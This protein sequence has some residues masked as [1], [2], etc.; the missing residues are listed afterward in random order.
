MRGVDEAREDFGQPVVAP[1]LPRAIVLALLHNHPASIV[2]DDEAV[3]V[4][5]IT[6]LQRG[7]VDLGRQAA[8]ARQQGA[9]QADPLANR[10]Q[11]RG[12]LPGVL[13][14]AAA[15]VQTKLPRQRVE[16]AFERP[17]NAGGDP[18]RVPVHP[19]DCAE[20]L[21]P[22]GMRKTPQQLVATVVMD[23]RLAHHSAQARHALRQPRRDAS[24]MERQVGAAC[25][26]SQGHLRVLMLF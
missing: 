2:G 6:V 19:H 20:R 10:D 21:K 12:R 17:Q 11:F 14:A 4:K 5:V 25:A 3:Q 1:G 16:P 23:D 13:P 24:A 15:H 8:G 26:L 18:R 9:V 7:A 22:E